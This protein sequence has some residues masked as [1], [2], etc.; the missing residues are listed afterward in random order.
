MKSGIRWLRNDPCCPKL[1][2]S[3]I[4]GLMNK[5]VHTI[6]PNAED[7]LALE[8]EELAGVVLE[9]FNSLPIHERESIHPGNF[10]NPNGFPVQHYPPQYQDRVGKALMEA[11]AWLVREN[12][13]APKPGSP[14]WFFV[15][16]RGERLKTASDV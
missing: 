6:L 4:L 14:E 8:P 10:V 13:I 3:L 9:H 12:L 11:W 1:A 7:L 5:Y 16:R 15:S 2:F